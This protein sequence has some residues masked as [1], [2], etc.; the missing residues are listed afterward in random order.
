MS[1]EERDVNGPEE[2]SSPQTMTEEE[3]V[4]AYRNQFVSS[5]VPEHLWQTTYQKITEEV[6]S[7]GQT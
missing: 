7:F 2:D 5:G 1:S 3:F 6:C 4:E